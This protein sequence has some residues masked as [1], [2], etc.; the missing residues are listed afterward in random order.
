MS[1]FRWNPG[2]RGCGTKELTASLWVGSDGLSG[3]NEHT[4]ETEGLHPS[5]VSFKV[6]RQALWFEKA[7]RGVSR[8]ATGHD[9]FPQE[10]PCCTLLYIISF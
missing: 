4:T 2:K 10:L 3:T 5:M 8:I 6:T 9:S 7:R 1:K